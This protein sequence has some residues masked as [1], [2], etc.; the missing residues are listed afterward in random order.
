MEVEPVRSGKRH[1]TFVAIET[2]EERMKR[3]R[4]VKE[5]REL[6]TSTQLFH[7]ALQS[8]ISDLKA[9][10]D[11]EFES[12]VRTM[13]MYLI[14]ELEQ[15]AKELKLWAERLRVKEECIE[16]DGEIRKLQAEKFWY[17]S[18][19]AALAAQ[20]QELRSAY[21]ALH[22]HSL[23]Q[24]ANN[25]SRGIELRSL[26]RANSQLETRLRGLASPRHSTH[27]STND[28]S[29]ALL[30]LPLSVLQELSPVRV[31]NLHVDELSEYQSLC[32][33]LSSVK[34]KLKTSKKLVRDMRTSQIAV[35]AE[36][37]PLEKLYRE[38]FEIVFVCALDSQTNRS[39]E[40]KTCSSPRA[41]PYRLVAEGRASLMKLIIALSYQQEVAEQLRLKVFPRKVLSP[42]SVKPLSSPRHRLMSSA[43][44][45][46]AESR[47]AA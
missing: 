24:K 9:Y 10:M 45:S 23:E 38:A 13:E 7:S 5:V 43:W 28:I 17:Q 20:E 2:V 32:E 34:G 31:G 37:N 18:R 29:S 3:E 27:K 22:S 40:S 35:A 26:M 11:Q 36:L 44:S 19:E 4:R 14:R 41:A 47:S 42:R 30:S 33:S 21:S 6:L 12:G 46:V 8:Q 15:K 39:L 25:R 16:N 1:G